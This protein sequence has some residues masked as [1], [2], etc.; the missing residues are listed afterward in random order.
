MKTENIPKTNI[1][2]EES[3]KALTEL[4]EVYREIHN[5]LVSEGKVRVENGKAI[6][7]TDNSKKG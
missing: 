2:S 1:L 7:I 6:F 4:G 5:R 3:I